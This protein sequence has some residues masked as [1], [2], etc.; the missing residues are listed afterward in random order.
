MSLA[1]SRHRLEMEEALEKCR[2]QFSA[3]KRNAITKA[4]VLSANTL[5]TLRGEVEKQ[6]K[7]TIEQ[8]ML[9]AR[10]DKE[11][12]L[13]YA[14]AASITSPTKSGDSGARLELL[15]GC[16]SGNLRDVGTILADRTVDSLASCGGADSLFL[17][18]HR[19]ISGYHF[20]SKAEVTIKILALLIER[21][22][23]QCDRLFWQLCYSQSSSC[24][25]VSVHR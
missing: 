23:S 15:N 25:A 18:L 14:S 21:R 19:A 9:Q 6:R 13:A 12:M 24:D 16:M 10:H 17:T 1:Q 22:R 2:A 5:H 7:S 8:C 4:V 11:K 3:E 20:H